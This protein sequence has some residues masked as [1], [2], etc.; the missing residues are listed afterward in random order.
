M[1][2]AKTDDKFNKILKITCSKRKKQEQFFNC[3]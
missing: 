1:A 3:K 2:N